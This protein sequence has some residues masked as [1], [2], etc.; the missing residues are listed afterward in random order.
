MPARTYRLRQRHPFLPILSARIQDVSNPHCCRDES[1][2][3]A[4]LLAPS[5][6][7]EKEAVKRRGFT[8]STVDMSLFTAVS[9]AAVAVTL[10][11]LQV[12]E[13][14][15]TRLVACTRP[16]DAFLSPLKSPRERPSGSRTR[17]SPPRPR[18]GGQR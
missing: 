2:L 4:T 13:A 18:S 9:T 7:L 17:I 6:S 11:A 16:E 5:R 8:F 14:A 15:A 12:V 1:W 10:S 3:R